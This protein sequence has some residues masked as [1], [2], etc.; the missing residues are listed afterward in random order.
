MTNLLDSVLTDPQYHFWNGSKTSGPSKVDGSFSEVFSFKGKGWYIVNCLS[1]RL[2]NRNSW[3]CSSEANNPLPLEILSLH[4]KSF[5]A[6]EETNLEAIFSYEIISTNLALVIALKVVSG[7]N[8][9]AAAFVPIPAVTEKKELE[10]LMDGNQWKSHDHK[11]FSNANEG[12]QRIAIRNIRAEIL[13]TEEEKS[14]LKIRIFA[15]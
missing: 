4:R 7:G 11:K 13:M 8:S 3:Y 2:S 15:V 1:V 5:F 10:A 14:L 6:S 9:F 12:M